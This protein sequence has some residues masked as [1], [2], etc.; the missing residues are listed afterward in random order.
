MLKSP[1]MKFASLKISFTVAITCALGLFSGGRCSVDAARER[2]EQTPDL[3]QSAPEAKLPGA[4]MTYCGPVAVSNSLIYLAEHG[5]PKLAPAHGSK[6]TQGELARKLAQYMGTNT[7]RG[8][9]VERLLNGVHRFVKDRGYAIDSLQYQGWEPHPASCSTGVKYPQVQFLENSLQ[10]DTAVWL[11]IGWYKYSSRT[12]LYHLFE[13]HWVTLVGCE[14]QENSSS[15]PAKPAADE[16][17]LIIHD[18]APRSGS[19]FSSERVRLEPITGGSFHT[20]DGHPAMPANGF[21]K[22]KGDLKIKPGA[23]CG[24]LDGVVVLKLKPV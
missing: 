12:G 13:G 7:K 11:K 5:Y 6:G 10:G 19:Q 23:D 16:D 15:V 18:P 20:I 24:I 4:G 14:S 9:S 22:L 8:T 21:F 17:V 1:R 2:I 3:M